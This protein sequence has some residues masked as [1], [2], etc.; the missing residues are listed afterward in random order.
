MVKMAEP[1]SRVT[2]TLGRS[3]QVVK[4][5]ASS[6]DFSFNDSQPAAGNKRSVRDRLGAAVD[7]TSQLSSKRQ[8]GD[9]NGWGSSASSGV[10]DARL[11]KDDLRFKIMRKSV[12]KRSQSSGQQTGVDLRSMLSRSAQS[13]VTPTNTQ[14]RMPE[15]KETRHR[16]PDTW[17]SRQRVLEGRDSRQRMTESRESRPLMPDT[18][19]S[20]QRM[21]E[22]K[23]VRYQVPDRQ[24]V[25]ILRQAPS[26]RNVDA[27]PLMDSMRSSFSPWTLE[28]LR[29]R[30]PDGI[31]SSRGVSPPRSG[32]ELQR[33]PTVRAYD[34]PRLGSYSSKDFSQFSRPMSSTYLSS[35][36][37]PAAPAKTMVPM[38]APIPHPGGL[39]Q[40][41]SYGVKGEDLPT[42]DGFLHSLGLEKYAI[43]FKAEE[44]DMHALKQMGDNDLKELGIPMGPRKKIILALLSRAKRQL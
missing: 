11:D 35:T 41:S 12:M 36:A 40:R 28:R 19:D 3:G 37:L 43:N 17:D 23:D 7:S 5:A 13:S 30:S 32:E 39:A 14:H 16:Y 42:V 4:K 29:R 20:R 31:L 2:I 22:L 21:P 27:L 9:G 38:H 44:V 18:R 8:R 24:S 1:P 26:S 15:P 34:D 10:D 25:D 6:I 33:R